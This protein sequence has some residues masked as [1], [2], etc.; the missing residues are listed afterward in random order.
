MSLTRIF[1]S[2][3]EEIIEDVERTQSENIRKAAEIVADTIKKDGIVYT[4]GTGH[5]HCVA[6]EIIYRAGGLA[7]VD[8]ILEPSLTG[9]T[10]V[11]K[12][13]QME[14]IEGIS[15]TIVEHRRMKDTDC[16]IIISNSGRN[17]A[18]IE[19][20][21]ECK[22]RGIPVIA[23]TSLAYSM[24]VNPRHSCGKRLCEVADIVIDNCGVFG[25]AAVKLENHDIPMGSTSNI[26][27][28]CIMHC[29]IIEAADML[30]Q[31]GITPPVF[32]SGNLDNCRE[33]NQ[34][35]L[36]RYWGRIKMW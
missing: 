17:A 36:N 16:I 1:L 23:V 12:S 11:V 22:K 25:D 20:A 21:L 27:G 15:K 35:L 32:I 30:L 26:V 2:K 29:I 13:E 28:N 4:F 34:E 33:I 8:A 5:S 24:R 10:D 31:K 7:P 3:V 6:E 9:T 14:R 18:P 19:M